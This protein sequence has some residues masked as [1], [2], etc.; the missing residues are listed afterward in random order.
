[1]TLTLRQ[2]II[3]NILFPVAVAI[4]IYFSGASV[5]GFC[6]NYLPDGLWAY[7][8]FSSMLI[9][10][11]RQINIFWSIII[12]I[13]FILFEVLQYFHVIKGTG[14]ILDIVTY[15]LFS[16]LSLLV[17]HLLIKTT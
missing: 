1:M 9:I 3:L 8:L 7:S 10:W 16:L 5:S 12:F 6:R 4:G 2:D 15:F 11:D 14:D 17:N 13:I